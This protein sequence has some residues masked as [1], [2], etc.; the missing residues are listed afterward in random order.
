MFLKPTAIVLLAFSIGMFLAPAAGAGT[1]NGTIH[2]RAEVVSMGGSFAYDTPD[3]SSTANM[4]TGSTTVVF[5]TDPSLGGAFTFQGMNEVNLGGTSCTFTGI[6]GQPETGVDSAWVGSTYAVDGPNGSI[7]E[8][9][10]SGHGC[11]SVSTGQFTFTETDTIFQG[12]GSYSGATGST[13]YTEAGI[14]LGPPP[15]GLGAFEWIRRNGTITLNL[16]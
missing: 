11:Y 5:P 14:T 2:S 10:A 6:F 12:T 8:E 16:P 3:K 4:L 13:T 9:G 7:F 15:G 1:F